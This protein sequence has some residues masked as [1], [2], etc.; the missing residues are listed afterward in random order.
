MQREVMDS[1]SCVE[2]SML[3]RR[4]K[5]GTHPCKPAYLPPLSHVCEDRLLADDGDEPRAVRGDC[6]RP[7]G[8][9]RRDDPR[10]FEAAPDVQHTQHGGS[11]GVPTQF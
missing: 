5:R 2:L 11:G 3:L 10:L 4:Q 8:V 1:V 9:E 7:A 6:Y